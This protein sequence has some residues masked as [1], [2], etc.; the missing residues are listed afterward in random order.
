[1]ENLL[2][3]TNFS[4]NLSPPL[5]GLSYTISD[6]D[7]EAVTQLTT[8]AGD[9]LEADIATVTVVVL[10]PTAAPE[11]STWALMLIGFAGMGYAGCRARKRGFLPV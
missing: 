10:S 11:P 2:K 9:L 8:A 3:S 1:M 4:W 7:E 5:K 6:D